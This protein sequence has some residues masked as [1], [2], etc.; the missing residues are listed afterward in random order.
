[1][2]LLDGHDALEIPVREVWLPVDVHS[3]EGMQLV[4][5]STRVVAKR[6]LE[7]FRQAA[8][9]A[10]PGEVGR[11]GKVHSVTHVDC[12]WYETRPHMCHTQRRIHCL[13]LPCHIRDMDT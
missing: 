13:L 4:M 1:M 9:T 2:S 11:L 5:D 7:K 8:S 6:A 10:V 3:P 12:T